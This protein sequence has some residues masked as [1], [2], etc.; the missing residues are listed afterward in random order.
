MGQTTIDQHVQDKSNKLKNFEIEAKY[1]FLMNSYSMQEN[2]KI[3]VIMNWLG[4]EGLRCIQIQP[5]NEEEKYQ[6]ST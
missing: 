4:C 1:I 5:Y 6:T 2:E 3:A